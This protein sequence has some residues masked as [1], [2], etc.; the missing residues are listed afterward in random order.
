MKRP[1]SAAGLVVAFGGAECHAAVHGFL[2][3]CVPLL[4]GFGWLDNA[5]RWRGNGGGHAKVFG[6][7]RFH[8]GDLLV[9]VFDRCFLHVC[10]PL[11]VD[12]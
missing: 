12:F 5:V 3:I 8:G 11:R 1:D 6:A 10:L 7:G 2:D 4:A 9:G